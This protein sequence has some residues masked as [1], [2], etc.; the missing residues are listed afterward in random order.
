MIRKVVFLG[1]VVST[2]SAASVPIQFS[3]PE[4]VQL[5][6]STRAMVSGDLD[7]DGLGD[8]ALLNND[9]AQI[10]LLF[11]LAEDADLKARKRAA[12]QDR[13]DPVL[14]DARFVSE[15]ITVGYSMFDLAVGDL[16]R[17]GRVD[18]AYTSRE[19]P[20]E[21]R[22]QSDGGDWVESYEI[23]DFEALGW[24]NTVK[25]TDI[26]NDGYDELVALAADAIRIYDSVESGQLGEPAIYY[27]T[28][29]NPFNLMLVDVTADGLDD[30]LY[31]STDG[32]QSLALREQLPGGGFGPELRHRMDRPART[33]HA[34]R[35]SSRQLAQLIAVDSRTGILEFLDLEHSTARG[36]LFSDLEPKPDIYPI[37]SKSGSVNTPSYA[38]G[39]FD[40]DG[41]QELVVT[42]TSKSEVMFFERTQVGYQAVKSFPTLS[43]AS[44]VTAGQFYDHAQMEL[45]VVS[46]EEKTLGLSRLS[47]HG[48]LSFPKQ[49]FE[50]AGE[51]VFVKAMDLDRDGFDELVVIG[52]TDEGTSDFRLSILVPEERLDR[53]S[54]WSVEFSYE[55]SGVRRDPSG[56][57]MLDT[58]GDGF[59]GIMIFVPREPP[60]FLSSVGIEPLRFREIASESTIR[61]SLLKGIRSSEVSIFDTNSDG[62]K[63]LVV[64]R[65]GFA[66]AYGFEQDEIVM[67]DQYNARRG[68]DKIATVLPQFDGD[69]LT[70]MALYVET[71]GKFQFLLPEADGV[72]RYAR[73][74]EVGQIKLVGAEILDQETESPSFL[75]AGEDRFWFFPSDLRK[76]FWKTVNTYETDLE[77]AH[78]SHVASADFN[79]D[80]R[81]DLIAVDGSENVADILTYE[82]GAFASQLFW[83]VFEQ[84]MH[85]QGRKG[86]KLEPR[87]ILIDDFNGDG[88]SDFS[89]LVHDRI[90]T[91]F[92][93]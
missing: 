1:F 75:L 21:I 29:E 51:P 63:E 80:G 43:N 23:D 55:L 92:S 10:E 53:L 15:P 26:D 44:S 58:F 69:K 12:R 40:G 6:W 68:S 56:V 22:F 85:Y 18:L 61:E 88:V 24:T 17:D 57:L 71:D 59:P 83:Q 4:I 16:N 84:N 41:V 11:Q 86:T 35:D 66:R 30:L 34:V 90:L 77:D 14:E 32:R 5:D 42:D 64:A 39:D 78:Y 33:I 28:G 25:I 50:F 91:Y 9:R 70:A 74:R 48:R 36:G 62:S 49:I 82:E 89:F 19:T 54:D 45:V 31:L 27:L 87:Q 3:A 8:I 20:L 7:G 81:L 60:V 73:S 76:K 37:I 52:K 38:L 2:A 67:V 79:N 47:A 65:T 93:E 13:W 46:E 72:Y